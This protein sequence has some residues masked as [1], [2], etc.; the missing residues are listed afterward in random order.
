MQCGGVQIVNIL[1]QKDI[2]IKFASCIFEKDEETGILCILLLQVFKT[3]TSQ[4]SFAKIKYYEKLIQMK[5][6]QL[7][8]II[9]SAFRFR[10]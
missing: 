6:T 5:T 4:V 9:I 2:V 3:F 8:F 7:N 10:L 1:I